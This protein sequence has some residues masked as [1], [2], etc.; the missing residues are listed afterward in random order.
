MAPVLD[1]YFNKVWLLSAFCE[2][3][4]K[5]ETKYGNEVSGKNRDVSAHVHWNDSAFWVRKRAERKQ[6]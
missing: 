2:T 1:F 5:S 6:I 3:N 4:T